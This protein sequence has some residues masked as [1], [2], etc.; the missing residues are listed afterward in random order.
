MEINH[1]GNI[2]EHS[3]VMAAPASS[4]DQCGDR[5]C[6]VVCPEPTTVSWIRAGET[7]VQPAD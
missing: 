3:V 1:L 5:S 7:G 6:T 4:R 2:T